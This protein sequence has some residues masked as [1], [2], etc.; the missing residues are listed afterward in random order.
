MKIGLTGTHSSGKTT[1]AKKLSKIDYFKDYTIF[2]D[3]SKIIRD[4]GFSINT[5]SSW[6]SQ[7]LFIG[8]RLNELS[9]NDFICD[10]TIIDVCSYTLSSNVIEEK[11]KKLFM[12]VYYNLISKYD[13]IFHVH[14][15]GIKLENNGLRNLSTEYRDEIYNTINEL[16]S[17]G[18]HY[19]NIVEIKSSDM[20]E[21]INI[22]LKNI[23][24]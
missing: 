13:Y 11:K 8:Q 4:L 5:E 24:K 18:K 23:I 7:H 17:T 2:T 16:C 19:T 12:E 3:Q 6:E 14:P 22:I 15:I 21:R 10:R 20:K 9:Y 1:L